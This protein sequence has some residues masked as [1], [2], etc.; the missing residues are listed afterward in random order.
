MSLQLEV[1]TLNPEGMFTSNEEVV[2]A[3]VI[4]KQQDKQVH[5]VKVS[6]ILNF[7]CPLNYDNRGRIHCLY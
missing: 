1:Q 2:I 5:S 4:Y 3:V 6:K 7:R